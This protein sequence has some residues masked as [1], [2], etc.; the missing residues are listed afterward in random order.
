[1]RQQDQVY[2]ATRCKHSETL[3]PH[4]TCSGSGETFN[5]QTVSVLAILS[6]KI[7]VVLALHKDNVHTSQ[8]DTCVSW[9]SLIFFQHCIQHAA[10]TPSSKCLGSPAHPVSVLLHST[11]NAGPFHLCL[12]FVGDPT[13]RLRLS[14]GGSPISSLIPFPVGHRAESSLHTTFLKLL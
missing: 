5:G 14:L 8:P 1:M 6:M 9:V 3:G 11:W 12:A 13:D 2:I 10:W 4:G 7:R